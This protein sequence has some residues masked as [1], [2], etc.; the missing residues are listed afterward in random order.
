MVG[1][2]KQLPNQLHMKLLNSF[3]SMQWQ[4]VGVPT[5]GFHRLGCAKRGNMHQ[6]GAHCV[7]AYGAWRGQHLR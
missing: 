3:K 7:R 6:F 2:L 1:M 4:E 5:L